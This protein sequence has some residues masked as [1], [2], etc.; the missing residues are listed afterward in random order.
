M[1]RGASD[2]QTRY[3]SNPADLIAAIGP[4]IAACCFAVREE[5]RSEFEGQFVYGSELFSDK[6]SQFHMDLVE[7]NRRQLLEAGVAAERISVIG[8]CTACTRL[9]DGR[10]KYFSHRAERGFTGRMLSVIGVAD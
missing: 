5:V 3:D 4:C 1:E 7:A 9:E 8:D 10:L 6:G 2:L